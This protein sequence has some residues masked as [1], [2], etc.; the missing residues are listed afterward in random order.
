M[1]ATAAGRF[2]IALFPIL[3]GL[4]GMGLALRRGAAFG[5][6]TELSELWLGM[7]SALLLVSSIFYA[8]KLAMNPKAIFADLAPPPA[9]A[10]AS[11]AGMAWMLWGA[12]LAPVIPQAAP[13]I[14]G[15]GVLIHWAAL[16][17]SVKMLLDPATAQ[18]KLV[19][20]LYLVF[21]GQI[22]APYGGVALGYGTLSLALFLSAL[23][24]WAALGFLLVRALRKAP[25]APPFP[26][27]P[28]LAIHLAPFV[29][30]A[31][32]ALAFDAA[33]SEAAALAMTAAGLPVAAWLLTK[34]RWMSAGGW[35][36]AWGAFTFPSAAMAGA[37]AACAQILGGG[38]ILSALSLLALALAAAIVLRV[39][40]GALRALRDGTLAPKPPRAAPKF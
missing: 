30:G 1:F 32:A 9:R 8:L 2:P 34:A 26:F 13:F 19:P 12:A 16:G 6:P 18:P 7:A 37:I 22:V 27:R 5:V 17:V 31:G 11:A 20:G 15:L 21:V 25:A 36:P 29:V 4:M 23:A 28:G 3:L 14:W 33:W 35:T 38:P 10:A 40:W 39:S 24:G